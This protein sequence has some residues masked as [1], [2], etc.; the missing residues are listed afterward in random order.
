MDEFLSTPDSLRHTRPADKMAPAS[1]GADG[2]ADLL[3]SCTKGETLTQISMELVAF[4]AN[5]FTK[6]D[7]TAMVTKLQ[8]VIREEIMEV[9]RDLTAL[10]Q[11][12][13]ELECEN[14]QAIQHS[15]AT[16]HATTRQGA[17]ILEPAQTGGGSG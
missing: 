12:V 4:S 10:E 1:P 15:Q 13:S 14:M 2:L 16:D 3:P 7:K 5:M 17:V 11:R 6:T 9:C 8:A